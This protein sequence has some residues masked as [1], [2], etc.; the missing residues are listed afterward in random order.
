MRLS[1]RI[2][3][4]SYRNRRSMQHMHVV[5]SSM[6]SIISGDENRACAESW[7]QTLGKRCVAGKRKWRKSWLGQTSN[8][9]LQKNMNNDTFS[10]RAVQSARDVGAQW[11]RGPFA[12]IG[13]AEAS[14]ATVSTLWHIAVQT[15]N[16]KDFILDYLPAR[17]KNPRSP[18]GQLVRVNQSSHFS[19]I[20]CK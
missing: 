13:T 4:L 14:T 18:V 11:V 7:R 20:T 17:W 8:R 6:Q 9:N 15:I 12:E 19:V 5:R 16:K 3:R 1:N 2:E 10:P